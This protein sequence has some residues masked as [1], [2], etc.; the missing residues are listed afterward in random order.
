[1]TIADTVLLAA[2]RLGR[3]AVRHLRWCPITRVCPWCVLCAVYVRVF[4]THAPALL[5]WLRTRELKDGV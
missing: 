3:H 1:M 5:R 4:R 2:V